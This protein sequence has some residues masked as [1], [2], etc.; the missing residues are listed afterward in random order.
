MDIKKENIA[1]EIVN[2]HLEKFA[3]RILTERPKDMMFEAYKIHMKGQNKFL[4][5]H[6]K[7][8]LVY[9]GRRIVPM[10]NEEGKIKNFVKLKGVPFVGRIKDSKTWE[11]T[12]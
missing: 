11:K 4:K 6:L 5:K 8:R 2:L 12:I 10:K 7:G 1:Q 3:G 9:P